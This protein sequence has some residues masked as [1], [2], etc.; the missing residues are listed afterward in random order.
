MCALRQE[1]AEHFLGV[2]DGR[3][4]GWRLRGNERRH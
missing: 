2:H 3:G 1:A 4:R